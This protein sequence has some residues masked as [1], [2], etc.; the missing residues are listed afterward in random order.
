M[1][2]RDRHEA[3]LA[4]IECQE[5][6]LSGVALVNISKTY[7]NG[8]RAVSDLSLEVA[9]GE[10]MVIVGPSG[11]GKT[12]VLRLIAGLEQLTKGEVRIGGRLANQLDPKDRNVAMVF[13]DYALYPHM[14]VR[15]NIAF[16]LVMRK[17]PREEIKQRVERVV[18]LLGIGELL[19]RKPHLLSGG[20]QQRVALGRAIVQEPTAFLFDEPLSNLDAGLRI[21]T[22]AEIKALQ[23]RLGTTTIY[24]THDQEEAMTLGDRVAVMCRGQLQQVDTPA[25][26]Y[27]HPKNRFV[28]SFIGAPPINLLDGR[29]ARRD[30]RLIFVEGPGEPSDGAKHLVLHKGW[31]KSVEPLVGRRVLLGLRPQAMSAPSRGTAGD[32]EN[33]IDVAIDHVEVLGEQMDVIGQTQFQSRL[34]ARIAARDDF[35]AS[36]TVTMRVDTRK[37]HFF[38][39]GG[40][41]RNLLS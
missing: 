33:T 27:G 29:I 1:I 39:P 37:L 11:S 31:H 41:G 3:D 17:V 13:Q 5:R 30:D 2:A 28:A 22:R 25:R 10:L 8:A 19:K 12:T 15:R 24:V 35:P 9:D 36:G 34:V 14:T 23:V 18:E 40:V 21:T 38:E 16:P 32:R 7:D 26:L 20:Q 6:A 4:A